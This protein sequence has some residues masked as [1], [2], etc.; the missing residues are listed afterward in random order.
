MSAKPGAAWILRQMLRRYFS[1]RIPQS[2][3]ELSYFLLFSFCP[4]LMFITAV[5]AR[6]DL[7]EYAIDTFTR[8][9]PES[10]QTMIHSYIGYLAQQPR[11][12]PLVFGT[13]LTIY[14]LSR[15]VRS[16]MNKVG[17]IF[18]VHRRVGM[19]SQIILSL[20]FTGGFLLSIIGT[21]ALVV[22][23]RTAF[24]VIRQWFPVPE[25]VTGA[26]ESA[27]MP[28]ALCIVFLF[29]LLVNKLIPNLRLTIRQALPGALLS[30]GSRMLIS[31]VFSFYVD[32]VARYSLLY[33]SLGTIIALMLWLYLT[34]ITLLLGPMLNH[35][36]MLRSGVLKPRHIKI[37]PPFD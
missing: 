3:A 25:V 32:N 26:L 34:S 37:G 19:L 6:I 33:G 11:I 4:L 27:S 10:V 14:F 35:I 15:A 22:F 7:S 36:L 18:E 16:L 30:Y 1:E 13:V 5:L 9:L 21:L 20:T 8:F 2:A 29:V 23:S 24:R 28:L 12:S 31:F 17:E